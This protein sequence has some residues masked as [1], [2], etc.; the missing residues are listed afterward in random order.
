MTK[1]LP[2]KKTAFPLGQNYPNPFNPNMSIQFQI[3]GED[4]VTIKIF[5]ILGRLVTTLI[6]EKMKPGT[7]HIQWDGK[8]NSGEQISNGFYICQLKFQNFIETRK[9]MLM[10]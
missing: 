1:L 5:N 8:D 7:Y 6:N 4:V 3:P 9:M 10:R 2:Q